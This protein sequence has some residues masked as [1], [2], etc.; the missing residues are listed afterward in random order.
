[1]LG[2]FL[3]Q[4]D[5]AYVHCIPGITRAPMAAA[6]M[7]AMLMGISFEEDKGIINQTRNVSFA[8]GERLQ[9]AWID[10]LLREGVTNA[11]VPT[12]FSCC[13]ANKTT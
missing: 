4:G 3:R 13:V 10:R 7:G 11:E 1:M 12:G 6:V 5:N 8:S 2:E 9:G